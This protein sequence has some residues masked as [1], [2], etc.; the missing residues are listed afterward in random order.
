MY[1]QY[2]KFSDT[3]YTHPGKTQSDTTSTAKP[4][5]GGSFTVVDGVTR[6]G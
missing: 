6:D 5:H 4:S 2:P 3:V 1:I